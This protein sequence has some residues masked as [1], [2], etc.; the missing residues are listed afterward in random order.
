MEGVTEYTYDAM[1]QLLTET[2]DGE[3]VNEM[4]YDS[5][6]NI[7]QK[8]GIR[9]TYS[10]GWNDRLAYYDGKAI[11]YDAQGNPLNYLGHTL[12]WEKGR[13]L[14]SF[15]G[16]SFTYNANG[17]RTSKTVDGVRHDYVLDGVNILRETWD[18]NVL[19]TL[20][21]NEDSVCG[22][23]Y[24]GVPY[25][26]H[27]NLQG[28]IIAIADRNGEVVARYTYDA[29][30]KCKIAV[31]S[32]NATIAE[33]NPYR[34]RAYYFDTETGLYYLQ[35]RYYDPEIGRFINEDQA[36]CLGTNGTV[37]GYNIFAYCENEPVARA[38]LCGYAWRAVITAVYVENNFLHYFYNKKM[39][40]N[41]GGYI[42]NQNTGNASKMWFGFFRSSHNGCGWIA[43]YNAL[44]MLN[45]YVAPYK[46]IAEYEI[47]G[48]VLG[49]LFGIRTNAIVSFFSLRGYK[50]TVTTKTSKFDSTAKKNRANI[51]YYWHGKGA[52]YVALKWQGSF[53]YGLNTFSNVLYSENKWGSSISSFLKNN[54]F[55]K[56]VLISIK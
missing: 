36:Y 25:Y 26:F 6:G 3:V 45:K 5:Y 19:E 34:Y 18:D 42:Y 27:K 49:G 14:K 9:Y 15:D 52:H 37:L 41:M 40:K 39:S 24:N 17:I 43:T 30:G 55:T 32:V 10:E 22:I 46:I 31:G 13:Q 23:V 50:V 48:A 8:N 53:F 38:D 11:T 56:A 7:L 16:I 4:V 21:D 1:G 54:N 20:Y 47:N 35:S 51:I 2:H 33:I 44:I 28:D 12:T 29:W